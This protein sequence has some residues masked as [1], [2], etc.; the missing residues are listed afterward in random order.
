MPTI[1]KSPTQHDIDP[2]ID[3]SIARESDPYNEFEDNKRLLASLF[4]YLFVTGIVPGTLNSKGALS[5]AAMRHVL[6]QFNTDFGKCTHLIFLLFGQ[7]RR[8]TGIRLLAAAVKNDT[9]SFRDFKDMSSDPTFLAQLD[10]AIQNPT[11]TESKQLIKKMDRIITVYAPKIP[12][13]DEARKSKLGVFAGIIRHFGWPTFFNTIAND[14]IGDMRCLRQLFTSTSNRTFP[15]NFMLPNGQ[16]F[17]HHLQNELP[18]HVS[19]TG[20]NDS[21]SSK[22][23][24]LHPTILLKEVVNNPV[25]SAENY[26]LLMETF[27]KD[28]YGRRNNSSDIKTSSG[29]YL[30][31]KGVF[32][33]YL[34]SFL[35]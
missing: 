12:F 21:T 28:I 30:Q 31:H 3:I 22:E 9:K 6:L 16:T 18:I 4:P 10:I 27:F 26:R 8:H 14:P 5:K 35:L 34:R 17:A 2:K 13:S 11:T 25:V 15:A 7:L 24:S 19:C 33:K 29:S 20:D 23:Y 1:P 32:G